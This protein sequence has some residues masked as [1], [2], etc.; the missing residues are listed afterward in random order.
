R[1]LHSRIATNASVRIGGANV[2]SPLASE[3]TSNPWA[4]GWPNSVE[5]AYSLSTWIG[6]KS[7]LTPAKLTISVWV[8]VLPSDSHCCPTSTSSKYKC[9]LVKATASLLG[10]SVPCR[11][12]GS[13][14]KR[15]LGGQ[16][17]D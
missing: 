3:K 13:V 14:R 6:L 1:K 15:H 17:A 9:I 5:R 2:P 11:F 7:P 8:T 4:I 16:E 10:R 12:S